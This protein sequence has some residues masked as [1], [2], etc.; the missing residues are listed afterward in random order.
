MAQE[1]N[2]AITSLSNAFAPDLSDR[3]TITADELTIGDIIKHDTGDLWQVLSEP[4]Y[5][6]SGIEFDV[7]WLDVDSPDNTQ[8]VCFAP[9]WRFELVSHQS[10]HLAPER[11]A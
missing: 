7:L 11:A 10:S 8:S 3:T 2:H 1:N 5:T 6:C 9:S 4:Q